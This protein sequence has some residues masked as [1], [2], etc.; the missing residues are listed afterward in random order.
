MEDLWFKRKKYG[1]G[2]VPVTWQGWAFVSLY[3]V[4]VIWG[5]ARLGQS[6]SIDGTA[7]FIADIAV[8]TLTLVT[9]CTLKGEHPR[10]QWG[11]DKK[12]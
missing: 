3:L 10:W 2:W 5:G 11:N 12:A 6:P 9:I 4:A 1:W 8:L 7:S